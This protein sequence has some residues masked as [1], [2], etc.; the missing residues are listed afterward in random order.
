[1]TMPVTTNDGTFI[2]SKDSA[3]EYLSSLGFDKF[4]IENLGTLLVGDILEEIAIDKQYC[5]D[6]QD[7]VYMILEAVG[8]MRDDIQDLCD[9]LGSGKGGTKIQYAKRIMEAFDSYGLV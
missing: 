5:Q 4:D 6:R 2:D 9:K 7:E 1:M 3:I 8:H